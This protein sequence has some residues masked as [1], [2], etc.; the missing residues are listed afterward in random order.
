VGLCLSSV[1]F[2]FPIGFTQGS[3]FAI[4]LFCIFYRSYSGVCVCLYLYFVFSIGVTQ[5]GIS[6]SLYFVSFIGVTQG[7][8]ST[9]YLFCISF[10]SY[11]GACVCHLSILYMYL[12]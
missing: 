5:G 3:V 11:T 2:V 10:R 1:Y 9:I 8:M 7:S 4:S 12:L 6:L